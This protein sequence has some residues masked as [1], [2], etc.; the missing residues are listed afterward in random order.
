MFGMARA[1]HIEVV[2]EGVETEAQ[3]DW[4]LRQGGHLQQGLL[5]SRAVTADAF[6]RLVAE[7]VT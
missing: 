3:R 6:Q 1:L 5:F 4:L 2:A 7:P